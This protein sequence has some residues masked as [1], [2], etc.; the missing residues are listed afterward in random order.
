MLCES[1]HGGSVQRTFQNLNRSWALSRAL[2]LP[3]SLA[4]SGTALA[5]TCPSALTASG[6]IAQ[7]MTLAQ[8]V[9]RYQGAPAPEAAR[10]YAL[11]SI[12]LHDAYE[13]T[14]GRAGYLLSFP[15]QTNADHDVAQVQINAAATLFSEQYSDAWEVVSRRN[16]DIAACSSEDDTK[17]G[18]DIGE[19]ISGQAPPPAKLKHFSP[20]ANKDTTWTSTPPYYSNPVFPLWAISTPFELQSADQFRPS[21]PPSLES[22]TYISA[23]LEVES[24]GGETSQNRSSSQSEIALFWADARGTSSGPGHW[25]DILAQVNGPQSVEEKLE[26][27][28][29]MNLAMYDA[30]IAAWDAKYHYRYWRPISSINFK[31]GIRDKIENEW[32]PFVENPSHPE[33]VSGHSTFSAAA[34]TVLTAIFGETSFCVGSE[35]LSNTERCFDSFSSA[36][37]EAGRSR[38]Y[39]GIHF[40]FS[41]E[42][43]LQLGR[44]VGEW[45]LS[46]Y[47]QRVGA[48]HNN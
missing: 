2:A 28:L 26:T 44:D 41:N 47:A 35:G 48:T 33:Y 4:L 11:V 39:G 15:S 19:Q 24:L 29:L 17:F 25:N 14:G 27:L 8:D 7:S 43:G 18:R 38:I 5:Q 3:I 36:A 9:V 23:A 42:D 40:S 22:D 16:P 13:I 31:K 32:L 46:S 34:A 1:Q 6:A 30:G 10:L 37:D 45:T 12:T 21:G 20:N